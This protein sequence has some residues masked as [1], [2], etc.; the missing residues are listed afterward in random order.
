LG[1]I[2][3]NLFPQKEVF[4][5]L[6]DHAFSIGMRIVDETATPELTLISHNF[7]FGLV[8]TGSVILG[9]RGRSW[10]LR[11]IGLCCAWLLLLLTQAGL[12]VAAAH[13][14]LL[15]VT[16]SEASLWVSVFIKSVHPMVAILPILMIAIWLA[17]PFEI[18]GPQ[19]RRRG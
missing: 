13:A 19:N 10:A 6:Q 14:Y 1:S 11:L 7:G 15:A 9:T 3:W 8:V 16:Q 17:I 2:A 5:S 18:L 12:L 4:L